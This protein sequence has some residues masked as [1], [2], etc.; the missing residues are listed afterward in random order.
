[1]AEFCNRTKQKKSNLESFRIEYGLNYI[2]TIST[3]GRTMGLKRIKDCYIMKVIF[4]SVSHS[5]K[6]I[7]L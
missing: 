2:E 1:M 4:L 3:T 5:M 7:K 6:Y